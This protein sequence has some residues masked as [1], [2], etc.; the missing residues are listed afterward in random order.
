[1]LQI[2]IQEPEGALTTFNAPKD[3]Y[4]PEQIA[5]SLELISVKC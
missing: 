3:K 2:R 1:M 4:S 5:R